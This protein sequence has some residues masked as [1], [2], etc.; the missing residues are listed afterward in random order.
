MR[1]PSLR[2]FQLPPTISHRWLSRAEL[3]ATGATGR[4]LTA[5]A[6]AGRVLRVRRGR[7]L[8]AHTHPAVV[9]AATAG[10]RLDCVSLLA[11]LGV[12]VFDAPRLHVQVDVGD[13]RLP[14]SHTGVVRHW[15][16]RSGDRSRVTTE[17]V[18]A[19]VASDRCQPPRAAIATLDSVLHL[20]AIDDDGLAEVFAALPR[21]YRR[22]RRLIDRRAESGSETFMRLI[23]RSI[24]ASFDAQAGIDGVGYVDF[25]VDGWLIIECDSEAHHSDWVQRKRDIRRERAALRRGY[26]TV[27]FLAEELFHSPGRVR[28]ELEALLSTDRSQLLRSGRIRRSQARG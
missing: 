21:R 20:G 24:G 23:L 12:F 10:G 22:L 14:P 13:S 18:E 4:D 28:E 11:A 8:P 26:T 17:V 5:A 7:Y 1:R 19:V 3:R 27:R 25:L 16:H 2:P 15:R 6:R 9:A